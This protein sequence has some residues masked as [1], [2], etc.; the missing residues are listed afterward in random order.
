MV[1]LSIR[2]FSNEKIKNAMLKVKGVGIQNKK[3]DEQSH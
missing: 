3:F 1:E 2:R